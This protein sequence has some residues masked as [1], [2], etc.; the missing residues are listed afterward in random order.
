MNGA[1]N[2]YPEVFTL[3]LKKNNVHNVLSTF[4]AFNKW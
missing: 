4:E 1:E 3:E 2:I